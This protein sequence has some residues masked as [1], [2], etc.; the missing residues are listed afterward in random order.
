MRAYAA[1]PPPE[2]PELL[3][4]LEAL[5]INE[6]SG[7]AA[8]AT[9]KQGRAK[10]TPAEQ[11]RRTLELG[12]LELMPLEEHDKLD[13]AIIE[14]SRL[15]MAAHPDEPSSAD[16]VPP[17]RPGGQVRIDGLRSRGELNGCTGVLV[18]WYED[19]SRWWV[20]VEYQ[21]DG[22]EWLE[23][24]MRIQPKNLVALPDSEPFTSEDDPHGEPGVCDVARFSWAERRPLQARALGA[25]F[26]E[27]GRPVWLAPPPAHVLETLRPRLTSN[28]PVFSGSIPDRVE[29]YR[30]LAGGR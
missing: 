8:G 14:Q 20:S 23:E 10:R 21:V 17:L 19:A 24:D 30:L 28:N 13:R 26:D 16:G 22:R 4:P 12:S 3:D 5:M 15:W 25:R 9:R 7:R 11:A 2:L 29:H 18:Q 1:G 27:A 6:L